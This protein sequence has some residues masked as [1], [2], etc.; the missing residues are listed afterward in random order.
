MCMAE[1]GIFRLLSYPTA[2]S[3]VCGAQ[4]GRHACTRM[5]WA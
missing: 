4:L 5:L 2:C 1:C 3:L